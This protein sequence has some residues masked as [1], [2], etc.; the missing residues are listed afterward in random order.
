MTEEKKTRNRPRTSA[1]SGS[2]AVDVAKRKRDEKKELGTIVILST[3]V[4]VRIVPVA[5]HIIDEAMFE[6]KDPLVPQQDMGKGRDEPNPLDPAYR[7]AL[8]DAEHARGIATSDTLILVGVQL[9]D[10]IPEDDTWL[11]H[12]KFLERLGHFKALSNFDL[13]DEMD[14]EFV[15]KKYYAISTRDFTLIG[16]AS[17]MSQEE[18]DLAVRG[19]QG[20]EGESPDNERESEEP[21]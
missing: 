6:I 5:A 15:F 10:G 18:I 16:N 1:G 4:R 14:L 7:Q 12:L 9:I 17:G 20:D 11:K 3:G 8:S 13:E 2:A 21:A 19:F